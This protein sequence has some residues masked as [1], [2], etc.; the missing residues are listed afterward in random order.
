MLRVKI[1]DASFGLRKNGHDI[2]LINIRT[3]C[4]NLDLEIFINALIIYFLNSTPQRNNVNVFNSYISSVI[5]I[6]VL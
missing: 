4:Y 1:C 6:T 5:L 2:D 3:Q